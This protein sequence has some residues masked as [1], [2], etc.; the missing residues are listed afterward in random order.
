MKKIGSIILAVLILMTS[1]V[2]AY[3]ADSATISYEDLKYVAGDVDCNEAIDTDDMVALRK[4]LIKTAEAELEKTADANGDGEINI[5]DL[6][7]LRKYFTFGP[8]VVLGK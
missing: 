3:A 8:S 7:R 2:V 6:V 5:V 4:I 1:S